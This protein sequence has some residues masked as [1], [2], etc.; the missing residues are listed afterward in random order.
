MHYIC[1]YIINA[2]TYILLADF[3]KIVVARGHWLQL[4]F[5]WSKKR[6][7]KDNIYLTPS[8]G[9]LDD[10]TARHRFVWQQRLKK[11]DP[12]AHLSLF[13][14]LVFEGNKI[15]TLLFFFFKGTCWIVSMWMFTFRVAPEEPFRCSLWFYELTALSFTWRHPVVCIEWLL[16]KTKW[17]QKTLILCGIM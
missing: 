12:K 7:D 14:S 4:L 1:T 16:Y 8:A 2:H 6:S 10:R 13:V 9:T 3:Q 11:C 5:S 17:F 15:I